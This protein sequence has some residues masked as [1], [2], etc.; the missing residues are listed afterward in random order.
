MANKFQK[1]IHVDKA[2][3]TPKRAVFDFG[4][5]MPLQNASATSRLCDINLGAGSL[6]D[7]GIYTLAWAAMALH[8]NPSEDNPASDEEEPIVTSSLTLNR[9]IDE[10]STVVL[11]YPKSQAQ[12][13][14]SS[15]YL[16]KSAA[17]FGRVEGTEGSIHIYGRVASR[18]NSLV[19][20][21]KGKE[22]RV[23]DFDFHGWGFFYEADAVAKNIRKGEKENETMPL[24]ETLRI[25]TMID[26]VRQ[27]NGMKYPQDNE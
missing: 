13:I 3:G 15:T 12:A 11:S 7:I 21:R 14:C 20:R 2:I 22:E 8:R 26:Q 1:L 6:L 16:Y 25:L 5:D 23:F 17:E 4:L 24:K 19:L 27:Q 10:M 9:G 18:P